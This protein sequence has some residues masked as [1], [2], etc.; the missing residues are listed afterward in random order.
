MLWVFCFL[1]RKSSSGAPGPPAVVD[2]GGLG[3]GE[4][5]VCTELRTAN[6]SPSP[7]SLR[8]APVFNTT[9]KL[10]SCRGGIVTTVECLRSHPQV[11]GEING[12]QVFL[13]G[14]AQPGHMQS[15][16]VL[17]YVWLKFW[18]RWQCLWH[19]LKCSKTK[20]K[21]T[22]SAQ[23]IPAD[24]PLPMETPVYARQEIKNIVL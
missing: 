21:Q 10:W 14:L 9:L 4:K 11:E 16:W 12:L 1:P 8:C 19:I 20:N 17:R 22:K 5:K 13:S 7:K 23:S 18:F 24:N 6:K 2:R 15:R 3:G